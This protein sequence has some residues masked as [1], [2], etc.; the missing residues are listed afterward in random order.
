MP[1][2][3]PYLVIGIIIGVPILFWLLIGTIGYHD[4]C[5]D[6]DAE[7]LLAEYPNQRTNPTHAM[8]LHHNQVEQ[9]YEKVE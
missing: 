2:Y 7:D 5:S 1:A 6:E 9:T 4:H 8:L 3:Y